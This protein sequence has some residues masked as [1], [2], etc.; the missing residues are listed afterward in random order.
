[1]SVMRVVRRE[2]VGVA[3]GGVGGRAAVGEVE[4]R[5]A[6]PRSRATEAGRAERK[7]GEKLLLAR[8]TSVG[9]PGLARRRLLLPEVVETLSTTEG[10]CFFA[11]AEPGVRRCDAADAL[12][13]RVGEGA[14]A[15]VAAEGR[16]DAGVEG[17]RVGEGRGRTCSE[18]VRML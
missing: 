18:G 5:R 15:G 14:G 10:S 2:R 6:C 8:R 1:M 4:R 12:L 11:V 9:R 13:V 3:E 16:T 7:G 17:G